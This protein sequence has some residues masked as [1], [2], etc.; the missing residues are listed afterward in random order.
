MFVS[1]RTTD[2]WSV[3]NLAKTESEANFEE[4]LEQLVTAGTTTPRCAAKLIRQYEQSSRAWQARERIEDEEA[5]IALPIQG[6][7]VIDYY[8]PASAGSGPAGE[9]EPV[10]LHLK[11]MIVDNETVLLGS[12]NQDRASW[13][14]SQELGVCLSSAEVAE[15]VSKAV[16]NRLSGRIRNIYTSAASSD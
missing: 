1:S 9:D 14:T 6:G 15:A 11:L 7:L 10:K 4:T 2:S 5:Q 12:G 3:L 8:S 13:Y 16:E